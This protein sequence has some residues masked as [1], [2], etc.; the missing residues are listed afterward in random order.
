MID[1]ASNYLCVGP[2]HLDSKEETN[3]VQKVDVSWQSISQMQP[4]SDGS[5]LLIVEVSASDFR[6]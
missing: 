1:I 3:S 6:P 2:R 5:E 4:K